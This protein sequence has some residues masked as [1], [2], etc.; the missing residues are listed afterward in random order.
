MGEVVRGRGLLSLGIH[1]LPIGTVDRV[2]AW[3]RVRSVMR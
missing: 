3:I 2:P 1:R